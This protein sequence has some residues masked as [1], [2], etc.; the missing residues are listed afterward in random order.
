MTLPDRS[1]ISKLFSMA[2]A[3]ITLTNFYGE[4]IIVDISVLDIL[5]KVHSATM[6]LL[7]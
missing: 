6:V 1:M 2:V 4:I 3:V 5:L 7:M